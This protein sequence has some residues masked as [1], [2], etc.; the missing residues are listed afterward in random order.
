MKLNEAQITKTLSQFRAQV[1][2]AAAR[3]MSQSQAG[4]VFVS[5]ALRQP[6]ARAA[7]SLVLKLR[8]FR[9]FERERDFALDRAIGTS[10]DGRHRR[11]T[12]STPPR[13]ATRG[14]RSGGARLLPRSPTETLH[15]SEMSSRTSAI[16]LLNCRYPGPSTKRIAQRAWDIVSFGTRCPR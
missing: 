4:E 8:R 11:R 6:E 13:S 3:E 5:R 12:T 1:L 9:T 7:F 2:A 15:F 16:L 14:V 10:R